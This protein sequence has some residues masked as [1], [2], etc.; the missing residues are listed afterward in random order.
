[1][2]QFISGAQNEE[3][4]PSLCS[5]DEWVWKSLLPPFIDD[6][7]MSTSR[8]AASATYWQTM[9]PKLWWIVLEVN[10]RTICRKVFELQIILLLVTI[11]VKG[12]LPKKFLLLQ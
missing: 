8:I 9:V 5:S 10:V 3:T 7:D 1:M 12:K 2:L 4:F 6:F 11:T